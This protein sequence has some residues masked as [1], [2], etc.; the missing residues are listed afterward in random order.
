MVTEGYN[1]LLGATRVYRE[2]QRVPE[3]YKGL[4]GFYKGLQGVTEDY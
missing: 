3:G 1:K 2:L 4:P